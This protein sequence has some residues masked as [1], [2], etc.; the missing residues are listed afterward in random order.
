MNDIYDLLTNP[1]FIFPTF[2]MMLVYT[3][4]V[5]PRMRKINE[6]KDNALP[7]EDKDIIFM[8]PKDVILFYFGYVVIIAVRVIFFM[9]LHI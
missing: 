2:V 4:I 3:Y 5:I 8:F 9:F 1:V 6:E 7:N